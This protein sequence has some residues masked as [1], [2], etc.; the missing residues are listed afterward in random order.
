M[1]HQWSAAEPKCVICSG[2]VWQVGND[3]ECPGYAASAVTPELEAWRAEVAV[4]IKVAGPTFSAK[5]VWAEAD[6]MMAERLK[7]RG[8]NHGRD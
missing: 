1:K 4:R 3:S 5:Y 7:R 2:E 8:G 6:E